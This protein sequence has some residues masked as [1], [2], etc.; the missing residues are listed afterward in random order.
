MTASRLCP[1]RVLQP[2]LMDDPA[3]GP[4]EFRR[5][6]QDLAVVNCVTLAYRPTLAFLGRAVRLA[7]EKPGWDRSLRILDVGGGYGDALRRI[8]RWAA[9]RGVAL[10]MTSIDLSPWARGAGEA[11]VA[12]R[13]PIRFVTA[14]IFGFEPDPAP[15]LVLSS[16][17]AHHLDDDGVVRFLDWMERHARLGWFVNDLERHWLPHAGFRA[18]SAAAGWH[19]FVRHDGPVSIRRAFTRTDWRLLLA[20][21]GLPVNT[22]RIEGWLPFRLCVSR[23]RPDPVPAA[24]PS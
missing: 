24:V 21:A 18:L 20:E 15:D 19:R 13:R 17:F 7:G 1:G 2:E 12:T 14:D 8:D 22:A 9:R 3:C 4:D 5:C 11:G 23:L 16:L 6:L 10:D